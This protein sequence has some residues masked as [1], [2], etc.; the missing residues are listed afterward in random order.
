MNKRNNDLANINYETSFQDDEVNTG[1]YNNKSNVVR[2][3]NTKCPD[4]PVTTPTIT[5]ENLDIPPRIPTDKLY[6]YNGELYFNGKTVDKSITYEQTIPE[7]LWH[8]S[9]NL[10]KLPSVMIVDSSNR[11]VEGGYVTYIDNNNI[12]I[13]FGSAFSGKVYLN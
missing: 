12:T 9:H 8:I 6:Q 5:L 11:I 1:N 2:I 13:E 4:N 7:I 3:H 10:N